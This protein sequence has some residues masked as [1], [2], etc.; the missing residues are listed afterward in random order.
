MLEN[1]EH[2]EQE[3]C[4]QIKVYDFHFED[5]FY[6]G[7][8]YYQDLVKYYFDNH[9]DFSSVEDL[10]LSFRAYLVNIIK[11]LDKLPFNPC[12]LPVK[13]YIIKTKKP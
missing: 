3:P 11:T 9:R 4:F 13:T 6:G 7:Y 2:Q 10:E 1:S 5:C 8:S 12:G